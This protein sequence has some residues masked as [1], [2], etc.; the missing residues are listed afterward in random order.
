MTELRYFKSTQTLTLPAALQV[1]AGASHVR[2]TPGEAIAVD[3]AK[4]QA[5]SR[6]IAG[7][8]RSGDFVELSASEYEAAINPAKAAK[9]K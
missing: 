2:L 6:F 1:G 5:E 3:A 8:V 4:C 7:R 9:G